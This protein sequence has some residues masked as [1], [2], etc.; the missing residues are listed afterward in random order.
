MLVDR[1][2]S[3]LKERRENILNGNINCIPLPFNRFK[4]EFPGVE[5]GKYFLVSG[6]SKAAKT[7]LTNFLFVYNTIFYA[8][9]HRDKV[10]P[11]IFYYPLEETQETITLR[12][13]AY[14]LYNFSNGK[15]RI[16]PTDL[17]S[18][19]E[20]KVLPQEILDLFETKEYKDI[21]Q[22]TA[23]TGEIDGQW[24]KEKY[25][26]GVLKLKEDGTYELTNFG[27]GF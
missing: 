23:A 4:N 20:S 1:V 13:M 11:K 12:F 15:I 27:T 25:N 17:K 24:V 26:C 9:H 7:Q 19:D 16:S 18:T 10:H 2:L 3:F 14:L 21:M 5:Q 8:F 22:F 6:G